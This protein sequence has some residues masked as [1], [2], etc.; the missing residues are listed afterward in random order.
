MLLDHSQF[1]KDTWEPLKHFRSKYDSEHCLSESVPDAAELSR[2]K[3]DIDK[4][5]L[6]AIRLSI[7]N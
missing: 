5:C 1:R 2:Q 6:N 3:K 4:F 7:I